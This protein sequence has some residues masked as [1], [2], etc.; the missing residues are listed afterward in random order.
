[1]STIYLGKLGS[2]RS[3]AYYYI[4]FILY[5]CKLRTEE[6]KNGLFWQS[7]VIF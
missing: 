5:F 3:D 4:K 7:Q 6:Q 1:M 2:N